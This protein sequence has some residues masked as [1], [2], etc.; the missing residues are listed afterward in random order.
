MAQYANLK[1]VQTLIPKINMGATTSPTA[2]EVDKILVST[3]SEIDSRL[4]AQGYTVP[5][6]SPDGFLTYLGLVCSYGAAAAILKGLFPDAV[7]A[8]ESPA[9]AF[10]EKRYQAE[11]QRLESGVAIPTTLSAGSGL[12]PRTYLTEH[13]DLTDDVDL[14]T[15]G[16]PFFNRRQVY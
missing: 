5:A 2:V 7:G 14:G 4:A 6:T 12:K 13:P 11:L 10:W 1:D 16:E 8:G 15:A 9:Y 3:S